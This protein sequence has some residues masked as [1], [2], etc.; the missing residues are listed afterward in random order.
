MKIGKCLL[1]FVLLT[2]TVVNSNISAEDWLPDPNLRIAIRETLREEIGL[3]NHTPL[4]KEHLKHLTGFR[5]MEQR[6][7]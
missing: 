4:T 3:P 6:N 1:A 7:K 5:S 2:L